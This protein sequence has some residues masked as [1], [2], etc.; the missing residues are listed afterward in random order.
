MFVPLLD[1]L[2]SRASGSRWLPETCSILRATE[3]A[4]GDGTAQSWATLAAN[5]RCAVQPTGSGSELEGARGGVVATSA[6]RIRLP[7]GQDVTAR[8]QIVVGPRTFEVKSVLARTFEVVR[9]AVCD[10]IT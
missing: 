6:W 1:G 5:V 9:V 3:A 8:D 4:D 2:R 7:H 10:E